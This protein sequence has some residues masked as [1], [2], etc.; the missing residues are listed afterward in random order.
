MVDAGDDGGKRRGI[1]EIAFNRLN[2]WRGSRAAARAQSRTSARTFR[3]RAKAALQPHH[4][5][6]IAI[7]QIRSLRFKFLAA[8]KTRMSLDRSVHDRL[9]HQH[10]LF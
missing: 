7:F 2:V 8:R 1:A 3:P 6:R 10:G 5:K 4:L 9:L